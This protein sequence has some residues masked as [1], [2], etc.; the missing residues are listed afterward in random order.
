MQQINEPPIHSKKNVVRSTSWFENGF[1]ARVPKLA[2]KPRFI[3][4]TN[5]AQQK[6]NES[7]RAVCLQI[8]RKGQIYIYSGLFSEK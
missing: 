1:E 2:D 6:D 5:S 3:E 4:K 8:G 7:H